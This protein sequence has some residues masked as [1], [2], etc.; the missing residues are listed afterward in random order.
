[1]TISPNARRVSKT[2]APVRSS[3]P[4]SLPDTRCP[5]RPA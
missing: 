5:P 1:V 2:M 4:P 3:L